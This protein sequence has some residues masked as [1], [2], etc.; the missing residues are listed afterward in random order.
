MATNSLAISK[1]AYDIFILFR[2]FYDTGLR[3][4]MTTFYVA[5]SYTFHTKLSACFLS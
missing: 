2:T 5:M 1:K 3:Q 4:R